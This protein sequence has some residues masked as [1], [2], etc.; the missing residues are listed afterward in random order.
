MAE[1]FF[2]AD[3]HFYHKNIIRYEHRPYASVPE[4]NEALIANWNKVVGPKDRVIHM[5]D[6]LFGGEK[7]AREILKRLNGRKSLIIGNHDDARLLQ[8]IGDCFEW[9][10]PYAYLKT[11]YGHFVLLHYPMLSWE[12]K[13]HGSIHL[14]GHVHSK[15]PQNIQKGDLMYNVGCDVNGYAPVSVFTI[16][17]R[18][19]KNKQRID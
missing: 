12:G 3:T 6:F 17:D 18:L 11:N 9:V 1:L 14:Y 15:E 19:G 7:A 2:T 5:G 4:M 8:K 13:S 10:K 16:L